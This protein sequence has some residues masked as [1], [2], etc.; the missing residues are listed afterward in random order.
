MC[1]LREKDPKIDKISIL[2]R[3]YPRL[4]N[5][6]HLLNAVYQGDSSYTPVEN[7]T[8]KITSQYCAPCRLP[9]VW[10]FHCKTL[11]KVL[12]WEHI[13]EAEKEDVCKDCTSQMNSYSV[14]RAGFKYT[15]NLTPSISETARYPVSI[16]SMAELIVFE[17]ENWTK[18]KINQVTEQAWNRFLNAPT[19]AKLFHHMSKIWFV[20]LADPPKL[21]KEKPIP[22]P[23]DMCEV[24]I[25]TREWCELCNQFHRRLDQGLLSYQLQE[26][27]SPFCE[28][29]WQDI[30]NHQGCMET[31]AQSTSR[32]SKMTQKTYHRLPH[33][34]DL[35]V[36]L[37]THP[38]RE[39][40]K[41]NPQVKGCQSLSKKTLQ[42]VWE[43]MPTKCAH[44]T[45]S[46]LSFALQQ[47]MNTV[48][49][50]NQAITQAAQ[51]HGQLF[52]NRL[53]TIAYYQ[54]LRGMV[55]D[56]VETLRFERNM[57]MGL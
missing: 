36:R 15:D 57:K 26:V 46:H 42:Q 24:C 51:L 4:A 43:S 48:F 10:C 41:A 29:C 38:E 55:Q 34:L 14:C 40:Y 17:H 7:S 23:T 39:G 31:Q 21:N 2:L 35:V 33:P 25:I 54:K 16:N 49:D 32:G 6:F 37:D 12:N 9:P 8:Y 27:D 56:E 50:I 52:S 13:E 5:V 28:E 30:I 44:F 20:G 47:N 3:E 11:H 53:I 45:C 18:K 19:L 22:F 1:H